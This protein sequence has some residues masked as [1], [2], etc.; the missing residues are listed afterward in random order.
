MS[1]L[2]EILAILVHKSRSTVDNCSD[3]A[4]SSSELVM[5]MLRAV[6][7]AHLIFWTCAGRKY[8]RA[9]T[10]SVCA[11]EVYSAKSGS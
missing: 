3:F 6:P 2:I 9:Q 1:L 4:N 8:T 10:C 11:L 5:I 7:A